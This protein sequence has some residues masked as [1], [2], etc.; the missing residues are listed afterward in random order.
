MKQ[1]HIRLTSLLFEQR[2]STILRQINEGS[3]VLT[4]DE[5]GFKDSDLEAFIKTMGD[6][7]EKAGKIKN[8]P[9]EVD[10]DAL[11]SGEKAE[12]QSEVTEALAAALLLAAPSLIKLIAKIIDWFVRK[13]KMSP[14]DQKKWKQYSEAYA[15][16]KKSGEL[17]KMSKEQQEK[18]FGYLW[19]SKASKFLGKLAE[20][21]HHVWVAPLRAALAGVAWLTMGIS[22]KDAWHESEKYANNIF[23]GIMLGVAGT[24]VVHAIHNITG[25]A[26]AAVNMGKTLSTAA[27]LG[28][29]AIK[30]ADMASSLVKAAAER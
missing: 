3:Y 2:F 4:E 11:R 13:V 12:T 29:D 16:A 19:N 23:A 8:A 18:A 26:S 22:W 15:E 1:Q 6:E 24:G 25:I 21:L 14:E 5:Q 7:L 20:T 17:E 30:G 27:H 10:M 9:E 28:A